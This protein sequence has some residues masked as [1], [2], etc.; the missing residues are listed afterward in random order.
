MKPNQ[1]LYTN[2]EIQG[3]K[4]KLQISMYMDPYTIMITLL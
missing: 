4:K 3:L 1:A 2:K